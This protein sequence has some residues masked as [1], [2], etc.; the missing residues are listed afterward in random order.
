MSFVHLHCHTHFS[1]LD[2]AM[3]PTAMVEEASR[4]GMSH[5]A[6]T[7][8]ANMAGIVEFS[9]AAKKNCIQP[10]YGATLWMEPHSENAEP[11]QLELIK[12]PKKKREAIE[13]H[14]ADIG[15]RVLLLVENA[16]GY[17]NLCELITRAHRRVYF[18]PRI[19]MAELQRHHEGIILVTGGPRGMPAMT[20]FPGATSEL[21]SLLTTMGADNLFLEVYD[22]G[23]PEHERANQIASELSDANG[24]P[25]LATN[26]TRYLTPQR[27]V[28]LETL[29]CV[30]TGKT[31]ADRDH[32]AAIHTD[33]AWFKPR[34]EM[35]ELFD[36]NALD[37]TMEIAERCDFTVE[38]GK[39]YLPTTTPP[40]EQ[41]SLWAKWRWL[42]DW[43]PTPERM[44]SLPC[45]GSVADEDKLDHDY[46]AAY[47]H[48]GLVVRLEDQPEELAFGDHQAY[49]KRLDYEIGVITEMGFPT[50]MLIVAEFVNWAKDN[51]VPTGPGRGSA[52]GSLVAWVMAITDINPLRFGLMFE[53]FL[54]PARQSMPDVDLDFSKADRERVISHV[55]DKYGTERVGQILTIGKMKTLA[56]LRDVGRAARLHFGDQNKWSKWFEE[57][58]DLTGSLQE[59]HLKDRYANDAVFRNVM[60]LGQDIHKMPRQTGVHAAGVI[61]SSREL[62]SFAPV[63]FNAKDAKSMVGVD[64]KAAETLGMVKF[65][66]LG[67]KTLD[68][69]EEAADNIEQRT[70]T[71]PEI[72][73]IPLDDAETFELLSRGDGLGLFQ[74]E[75]SGMRNLMARLKPGHI[76]EIVALVALYRPGPLSSGMVDQFIECKH[77]K[78]DVHYPHELLEDVLKPTFGVIVYQEQVMSAARVLAGYSLAEADLLRRAMGKKIAEE[79]AAQKDRFIQG[80]VENGLTEKK[81]SE[82]FD[83]IDHFS[84][85]GF[86]K[87]HSA[88]YGVI[89]Y[90]TAYLKA[91]WR[92]DFMA[93]S[94]SWEQ[95]DKIKLSEYVF[96]CIQSGIDVL[97]PDLAHSERRFTVESDEDDKLSIRYGFEAIKG[98]GIAA[99]SMLLEERSGG[100]FTSFED[101][102]HRKPS[103][104]TKATVGAMAKA[105]VFDSFGIE[106]YLAVPELERITAEIKNARRKKPKVLEPADPAVPWTYSERMKNEMS[107]LGFWISG[108]PLDRYI[109]VERRFRTVDTISLK[110][111]DAGQ[112]L[113]LIGVVHRIHKIRTQHGDEMVF[114]TVAD[115]KGMAEV[116]LVPDIYARFKRHIEV[117]NPLVVGGI[118]ERSGEEGKL[119]VDEV[120][121]LRAIRHRTA[122]TVH[123]HLVTSELERS[124]LEEL[125]TIVN[126][127][128]GKCPLVLIV[129]EE[130]DQEPIGKSARL[131]YLIDP[132]PEFFEAIEALTG[133]PHAA[134]T[135]S[136]ATSTT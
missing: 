64:M 68:I 12:A 127:Y 44:G 9:K 135:P 21:E 49:S 3:S 35:D 40:P 15:Y 60:H 118:M 26:A 72:G 88:S 79:M 67:L 61:I 82:I 125:V 16:T 117:G 109:D 54:N 71:R 6:M 17:R 63:H 132:S 48:R 69:L 8:N 47:A 95:G 11:P 86:N 50:Y 43:M 116:V 58:K 24:V 101:F 65:D 37:R 100:Y 96:D 36:G 2:G 114:L 62:T 31:L 42:C 130:L 87:A 7:D 129:H 55:R 92:A 111:Q 124:L 13:A 80:S 93:S 131:G 83:L 34:I 14:Y 98:V 112:T 90:Q 10:I 128:A 121:D 18:T 32:P 119:R 136:S 70:N 103:K 29:H 106:R 56:A 19:S 113:N 51:G 28:T 134:R 25:L 4:L 133:R 105:G 115:R 52:A 33:Q 38:M 99:I 81:A 41:K 74:V 123:L 108:H 66:F 46:F 22:H 39:I 77:G 120:D 94:M 76:E 78:E 1:F 20:K 122:T 107:V 102:V 73:K 27:C 97:P 45:P 75:S 85:Y 30:A 23:L 91:H 84:G 57:A 53:R 59:Q 110:Q 104:V 5:V 89:C 126:D